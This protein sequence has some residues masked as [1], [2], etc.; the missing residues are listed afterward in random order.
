[1]LKRLELWSKLLLALAAAALLWRPRRRWWVVEKLRAPRRILLVRIDERVGEALLTTPL[2]RALRRRSD[3][4]EVHV[5]VHRKVARVLRG[6]PEIDALHALDARD[7]LLGPLSPAIRRARGRG[8]DVVVNCASW[9]SP[10]VGPAIVSRLVAP[11]AVV[12]GPDVAPIRWLHDVSLARL[13]DTRSEVRQRLHLLSPL[14]VDTSE[15]ALSF[16][17]VEPDETVRGVRAAI[18]GR[19]Y[20]VVNPGGRVGARRVPPE[21]FSAAARAL[22]EAGIA[23]I[24]TWGPGEEDLAQRCVEGA[25]GA[26]LAPRTSIDQLAALMRGARLTV[27]NNTGPM[28]LSVAVGTPTLALFLRMEMARWGHAHAPHQMIDVSSLEDPIAEA[29]RA[30]R[31]FAAALSGQAA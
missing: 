3:R 22:A 27:C 5:L 18:G 6:H 21:V 16:R 19:P 2:F 20:A 29:A 10:S 7:R 1:V 28:H 13:R 30:A 12:I 23:P 26:S 9:E 4:P 25:P 11:R 17:P 8:F 14:G 31:A 15:T 24:V